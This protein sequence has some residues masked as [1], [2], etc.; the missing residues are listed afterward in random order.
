MHTT[1]ARAKEAHLKFTCDPSNVA[2]NHYEAILLLNKPTESHTEE[3]VTKKSPCPST[4]EQA[5]SL[6]YADDVIDLT[7]DSDMTT[8]QQSHSLQNN[9]SSEL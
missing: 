3:E 1:H 7:D 5:T 6:D 2:N 9:T 4:L 8:F